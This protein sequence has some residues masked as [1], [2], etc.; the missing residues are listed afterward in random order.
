MKNI[1][2]LRASADPVQL[3]EIDI[4]LSRILK[5]DRAN[6]IAHPEI[7]LNCFQAIK[8]WRAIRALKNNI[9]LAYIIGQKEFFNLNFLV[10][11]NVL[12][13]RPETELMVEEAI[14]VIARHA[15]LSGRQEVPWQ[16][17]IALIDIGTGTGCIPVAIGKKFP[18]IKI[19][20]TDISRTALRVTKKNAKRYNVNIKFLHGDLLEPIS[21]LL[22]A[23]YQL[24]ITAN[25][26]YLTRAWTEAEPSIAKEPRLALIADETNGLSLYEK[27]FQQIQLLKNDWEL[28]MEIDPR[29]TAA[30]LQLAKTYWPNANIEIK[31]DLAGRDRVML[32]G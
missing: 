2:D 7:K 29:Q 27:L 10:N 8:F 13:P 3:K 31:K 24:L 22:T 23:N 18:D 25:L 14:R 12:I 21:K 4:I 32:I 16:S 9:P 19:F 6:L 15:C 5:C 28:I 1:N 20:A 17:K 26:P 30:A 11:K